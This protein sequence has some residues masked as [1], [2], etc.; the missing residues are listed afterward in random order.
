MRHGRLMS[1]K[2][3]ENLLY[4]FGLGRG[5]RN[6]KMCGSGGGT[7]RKFHYLVES[8][9]LSLGGASTSLVTLN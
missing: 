7:P 1:L 2:D 8:S 5:R 6:S 3:P 9:N 4:D